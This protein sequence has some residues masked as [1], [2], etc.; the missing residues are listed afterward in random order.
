ML[1]SI[2]AFIRR[3]GAQYVAECLEVDAI[4]SGA[5]LDETVENI[6][7]EVSRSLVG[8]DMA[9][10]GLISDPMLFITVE[11]VPLMKHRMEC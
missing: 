6:R 7:F 10:M 9:A 8:V 5:T 1:H 3:D 4:A 2:K 11:D